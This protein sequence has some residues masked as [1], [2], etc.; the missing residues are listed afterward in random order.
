MVAALIPSVNVLPIRR[1]GSAAK[2]ILRLVV[3]LIV[4]TAMTLHQ[5]FLLQTMMI[6]R[7]A[8]HT[9]AI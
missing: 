1:S 3:T 9:R 8:P 2:F 5:T 4:F 7:D 6:F